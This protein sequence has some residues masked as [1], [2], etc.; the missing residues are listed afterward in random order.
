MEY[1]FSDE[2]AAD[3]VNGI[4]R[5]DFGL[6]VGFDLWATWLGSLPGRFGIA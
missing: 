5:G 2:I 4:L 6:I 3:E 1:P